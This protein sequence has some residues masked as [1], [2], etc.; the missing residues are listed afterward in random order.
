M[1]RQRQRSF[2]VPPGQTCPSS[3]VAAAQHDRV[4]VSEDTPRPSDLF[5]AQAYLARHP[6]LYTDK[7]AVLDLAY[8]EYCQRKEAGLPPD[9]DSFCER[10]P[11]FQ[12][13]IRKVLEVQRLL[14]DNPELLEECQPVAWPEPGQNFVGFNLVRELGRGAFAQ[15]FLATEPALGHRPVA[16]KVSLEGATEAETL[17][18]L[19]H[20]NIVPVHSVQQDPE[21]G[22]TVVC[23]PYLGRATLCDVI[24]RA[25]ADGK[26]S[27][28]TG[29]VIDEAVAEPLPETG[30]L[31]GGS[32]RQNE[33]SARAY[34][35]VI[36][37]IVAQLA[38]ALAFIHA[39]G[40][41]HG[42]LKPSNVLLSPTGTPMLLD[43][44][45]ARDRRLHA[46]RLGGTFPYMSPEL[47]LALDTERRPDSSL[48]DSR[49]DVFSLGV[50][51][52]EL[53]TGKHPF[54]PVSL[55]LSASQLRKRLLER[56]RSGPNPLRAACAYADHSLARLVE[57][58]L[59]YNPNDRP[60][61]PELARLLRRSLSRWHRLRRW[62]RHHRL[63][64]MGAACLLMAINGIGIY[65]L[66]QRESATVLQMRQGVTAYQQGDYLQAIQAFSKAIEA[67]PNL[68]DVSFARGRAYHRR[69]LQ[70]DSLRRRLIEEGAPSKDI[71]DFEQRI[72]IERRSALT[73]YKAADP[74]RDGRIWAC[75]GY[76][77]SL[78][79]D[80]VQAIG[81]YDE[82]LKAGFRTAE[83]YNNRGYEHLRLHA[84]DAAERDFQAAIQLDC[85]LGVAY[86]NLAKLEEERLTRKLPEGN[87]E[88]ALSCI[89]NAIRLQPDAGELYRD[90]AFLCLL[91]SATDTRKRDMALEALNSAWKHGYDLRKLQQEA[92]M[93]L[94]SDPR[95]PELVSRA[96][97]Q[98]SSQPILRLVDPIGSGSDPAILVL[99]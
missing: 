4:A 1:N 28:R 52:Y 63:A 15:V 53:L 42:D 24:D 98:T 35:D 40:I 95:F 14:E 62:V 9:P 66:A 23:M 57:R 45:L 89:E 49:S 17:G 51:L 65:A 10:F 37:E 6:Q 25:F 61:A 29:R 36:L 27:P 7:Q 74:S 43:F 50:I 55:K 33:P 67:D 26:G 69:A 79:A 58:C 13:S 54:G 94:R 34:G 5:D 21:S 19:N 44:N 90:K 84:L 78:D 73:D 47:L 32:P 72:R 82:A 83:V 68:V 48:I 59:A 31:R 60:E 41:C 12:N 80:H 85:R 3:S 81:F 71:K 70:L 92:P 39:R 77:F 99:H 91:A 88:T 96:R 20:T 11:G 22:L 16:L 86:H 30:S 56:Q 38:D 18:R 46:Q 87:L 76:C 64:V 2:Y 75:I 93:A 97:T 8:E